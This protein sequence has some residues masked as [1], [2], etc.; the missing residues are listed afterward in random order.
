MIRTIKILLIILSIE[1]IIFKKNIYIFY[2]FNYINV[3][4]TIFNW[5]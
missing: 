1:K 5:L 3:Y 2:P 4:E